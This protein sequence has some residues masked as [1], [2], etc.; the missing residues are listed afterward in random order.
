MNQTLYLECY[1]GISGDMMT[2]ALLDLGADEK[3]LSEALES[4]PVKGVRTE[5]RRVSKAGLDAC[6]F[7]VILDHE[8]MRTTTTI[9]NIFTDTATTILTEITDI[10]LMTTKHRGL[11]EILE[12]PLQGTDHGRCKREGGENF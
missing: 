1:S 3:V 5:V 8:N 2:A 7:H 11:A 6:D 4:L 10:I 9:W 12:I